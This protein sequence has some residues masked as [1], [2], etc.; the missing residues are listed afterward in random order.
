MKIKRTFSLLTFLSN[1]LV[2]PCCI[3]NLKYPSNQ[4]LQQQVS[5][6]C[7]FSLIVVAY[8]V[9]D[10]IV[11]VSDFVVVVDIMFFVIVIVV[12]VAF[13]LVVGIVAFDFVCYCYCFL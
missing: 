6:H 10:V 13:V 11:L 2:K 8:V 3:P 1:I 9:V 12:L 7:C 5:F 4:H